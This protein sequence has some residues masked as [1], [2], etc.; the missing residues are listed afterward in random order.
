ME[1]QSIE[2]A[3]TKGE[4]LAWFPVHEGHTYIAHWELDKYAKKPRPHWSVFGWMWGQNL[5]RASQPTHWMP[6]PTPPRRGGLLVAEQREIAHKECVIQ[7][8]HDRDRR[9][10]DLREWLQRQTHLHQNSERLKAFRD[11]LHILE[12]YGVDAQIVLCAC[13]DNPATRDVD[14]FKVCDSCK[15]EDR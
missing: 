5:L 11:V 7:Q 6:L 12:D 4:F 15:G 14:G 3:P 2:T 10:S 8:S 1:W 9:Q 13:C